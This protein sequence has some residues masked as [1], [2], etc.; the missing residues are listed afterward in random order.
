MAAVAERLALR[1][2]AAA[3]RRAQR[4]R[5]VLDRELGVERERPI[6][7]HAHQIDRRRRFV[8]AAV[9]P[10]IGDRAGGARVCDLRNGLGGRIVGLDPGALHVGYEHIRPPQHAMARVDTF[11]PVE[12]DHD[13]AAA[14]FLGHGSLP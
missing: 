13:V 6:L 3:Q 9:E 14:V 11:V 1:G 5:F 7:A 2:A 10:L 8:V 4:L 12:A